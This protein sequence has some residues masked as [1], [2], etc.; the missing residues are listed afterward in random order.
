MTIEQFLYSLRRRLCWRALVRHIPIR[1]I[2]LKGLDSFAGLHASNDPSH[3]FASSFPQAASYA[4]LMSPTVMTR[5]P[6][7]TQW[8]GE[9]HAARSR[10]RGRVRRH[11][12]PR[13]SGM[14]LHNDRYRRR[15]CPKALQQRDASLA[16][17]ETPTGKRRGSGVPAVFQCSEGYLTESLNWEIVVLRPGGRSHSSTQHPSLCCG[18]GCFLDCRRSLLRVSVPRPNARGVDDR[19]LVRASRCGRRRTFDDHVWVWNTA[20]QNAI[21]PSQDSGAASGVRVSRTNHALQLRPNNGRQECCQP[22]LHS[23]LLWVNW[24][25]SLGCRRSRVRGWGRRATDSMRPAAF[26]DRTSTHR[27]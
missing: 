9:A 7:C 27:L 16:A 6:N 18:T 2:S 1:P 10:A 19:P 25:T 3:S 5:T 23:G 21:L 24:D 12:R 22:D 11:T 17:R 15:R 13:L 8:H 4:Q 26:L 20:Y 14:L